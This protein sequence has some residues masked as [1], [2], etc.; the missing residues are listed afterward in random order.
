MEQK[1]FLINKRIE[2]F[3]FAFNGLRILIREEH[4]ARIHL[5]IAI[6]VVVVGFILKI[7]VTEWIAIILVIG[8]VSTLEIVNSSIENIADFISP[9]KHE[10]VKKIK[11][12]SAGSVLVSSI[13]ALIIGLIIFLPKII[14][15]I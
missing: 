9:E 12:L 11:D 4:N 14:E 5:F 10:I 8:F 7:S 3:G 1:K 13:T 2:S 15:L 6:F